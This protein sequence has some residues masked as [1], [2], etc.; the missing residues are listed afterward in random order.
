M[1]ER[2]NGIPEKIK[3]YLILETRRN[4]LFWAYYDVPYPPSVEREIEKIDKK[5]EALGKIPEVQEFLKRRKERAEKR[6]EEFRKILR[7]S[8]SACRAKKENLDEF[9]PC[10][11]EELRK[12]E[13]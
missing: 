5:L 12:R 8:F 4:Q 10:V 9:V 3:E 1:G 11:K 7:K 2:I 13:I 6:W